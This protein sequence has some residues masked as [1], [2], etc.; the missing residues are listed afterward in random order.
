MTDR[1]RGV[2]L[3]EAMI[4]LAIGTMI[5]LPT[6]NFMISSRNYAYRGYDRIESLSFARIIVEKVRRDLKAACYDRGHDFTTDAARRSFSFFTFPTEEIGAVA[7]LDRARPPANRVTYTFDPT[8]RTLTRSVKAHPRV[9]GGTVRTVRSDVVARNVVV[10]NLRKRW[11]FGGAFYE[12]EV[13]CES[14]HPSRK[15]ESTHLHASVRPAFATA[16]DRHPF[17]IPNRLSVLDP[18]TP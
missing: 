18:V 15:L 10:F 5:L 7:M 12:I 1:R 6:I 8:R 3:I 11:L 9:A 16:I 13:K 2:S 17:Q 4:V 14:S